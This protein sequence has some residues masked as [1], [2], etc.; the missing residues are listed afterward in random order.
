[1]ADGVVHT[2]HVSWAIAGRME[3]ARARRAIPA[4]LGFIML[5]GIPP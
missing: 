2:T 5:I 3:T 1:V 4:V